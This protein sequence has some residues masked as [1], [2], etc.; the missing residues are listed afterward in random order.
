MRLIVSRSSSNLLKSNQLQSSF[1]HHQNLD[2]CS[3]S[4][5]PLPPHQNSIVQGDAKYVEN[6]KQCIQTSDIV[7]S[8]VGT[9]RLFDPRLMKSRADNDAWRNM[10]FM[11][12]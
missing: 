11:E 4:E 8:G 12:T 10:G 2:P 3:K 5:T 6:V 7:V 9:S 1:E